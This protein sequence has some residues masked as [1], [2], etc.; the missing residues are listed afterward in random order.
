MSDSLPHTI[1]L[2]DDHVL[3]VDGLAHWIEKNAPDFTV[4]AVLASWEELVQHESFPPDLV[5]MAR[6]IESPSTLQ[7]RI[8]VCTAAGARVVVMSTE[9]GAEAEQDTLDAGADAFIPKSRPAEA[10]LDAARRALRNEGATVPCPPREDTVRSSAPDEWQRRVLRLYATGQSTVDI[11][12]IEGVRFD[13]V[14][15]ALKQIRAF[16]A[17]QGRSVATR[18]DLLRRAAEDGYLAP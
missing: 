14:R 3:V 6:K 7:E 9:T 15:I 10:V 12:I 1:A 17:E 8:A 2:L 18:D 4:V 5:L 13:R 11:A 16:Y